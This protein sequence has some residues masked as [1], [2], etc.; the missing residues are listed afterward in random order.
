MPKQETLENVSEIPQENL[1]VEPN[2]EPQ[3]SQPAST[4]EPPTSEQ[5]DAIPNFNLE[6]H[7][8][9]SPIAFETLADDTPL[10]SNLSSPT[11]E[12]LMDEIVIP[13]DLMLP[14]QESILMQ[15]VDVDHSLE[16]PSLYPKID[17]SNIKIICRKRK[18]PE[19]Q[20]PYR[21]PYPVLNQ[22][23]EPN[24]ELLT[25]SINISLMSFL[26][27]EEEAFA[28]PFDIDAEIRALKAR[29]GDALELLG[30]YLKEKIKGRGVQILRQV[31]DFAEHSNAPRLTNY[32]HLED[33]IL[34][35]QVFAAIQEDVRKAFEEAKRIAAE[36][37][38]AER[39]ASEE[40]AKKLAEQ[41]ALKVAVEMASGIAAVEVQMLAEA[42]EMGPNQDQ[43]TTMTEQVTPEQA[44][45][46]GKTVVVDKTPPNSPVRT[47]RTLGSPSSAIPPAVQV[48]LD[49]M[50]AEMNVEI[51]E[52]KADNKAKD[53]KMDKMLFF[54]EDLSD[55]LPPIS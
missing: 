13:S 12:Q 6:H 50:K 35:E 42:Q 20:L 30:S 19:P 49:E 7:I 40:E 8:P 47:L 23:S 45:D 24:V 22:N 36:E 51:S 53:E 11:S 10:S 29:F 38:E 2:N 33:R 31:M 16:P 4:F 15:S 48:A 46:R 9:L 18:K 25:S 37:A 3:I 39:I 43:D 41:E 14:I 27:M 52:L 1:N 55:R 32:N 28:F 21:E 5:C 34:S 54:L 17:I 26:S 44:S